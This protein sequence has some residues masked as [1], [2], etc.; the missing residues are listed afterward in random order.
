MQGEKP[1]TLIPGD[2]LLYNSGGLF[3]WAIRVKTWS[4]VN[5][6]ETYIGNAESVGSRERYG[7]NTYALRFKGLRYV[8]RPTVPFRLDH[9]MLWHKGV[10]GQKYDYK[11]LL[12]FYLAVKAGDN[13]RMFCSEH[14][15]RMANVMGIFPF[16]RRYD[17]DRVAP[18]HFLATD[19]YE[20]FNVDDPTE[21]KY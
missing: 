6:V 21:I 13:N 4:D 20:V 7:V 5:H 10:I 16:G 14:T 2:V 18:A 11:G 19:K 12:V 3:P 1:V 9:G 8:C 17:A 15:T